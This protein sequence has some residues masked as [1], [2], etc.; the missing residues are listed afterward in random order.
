MRPWQD[1]PQPQVPAQL[2]QGQP[3]PQTKD[4]SLAGTSRWS[5]E[6]GEDRQVWFYYLCTK[7]GPWLDQQHQA[8]E[9]L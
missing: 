5:Q 1:L 6:E 7:P 9:G 3:R 2:L 4:E 8:E